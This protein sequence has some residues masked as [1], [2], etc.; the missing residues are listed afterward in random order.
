MD[1]ADPWRRDHV[2]ILLREREERLARRRDKR[3][4]IGR[5]A[6][7]AVVDEAV[8]RGFDEVVAIWEDGDLGPGKFFTAMGFEVVGET[9]Y[10]EVI[11]IRKLS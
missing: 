11:G 9:Q 3:K 2:S 1:A 6:V 7:D 8:N 5:F 4:G 10:G